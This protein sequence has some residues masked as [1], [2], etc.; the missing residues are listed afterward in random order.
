MKKAFL[1]IGCLLLLCL[2][3]QT[4]M[5]QD[6]SPPTVTFVAPG[7]GN[8]TRNQT[9]LLIISYSDPSGINTGSVSLTVDLGVYEADVTEWEST[10]ITE[11]NII[12]S[13]PESNRLDDGNYTVTVSVSDM[14]GNTASQTWTFYVNT[15]TSPSE[16]TA[17]NLFQY[18]VYA[19]I[20]AGIGGLALAVYILYLKKTKDFTFRKYFVQH[21][22][23]REYLVIYLPAVAALLFV[24]VG[25]AFVGS[26][27]SP[28]S[29]AY[30][31]VIIAG[32]LIGIGVYAVDAQLERRRVDKYERAFSQFLFEL[33]DVC[34]GGIDPTKG[35]IELSK[36]DTS[37]IQDHLQRAA[38]SIRIGRPLDEV[39]QRMVRPMKSDLIRRYTS[40]IEEAWKTG[41]DIAPVIYRAAKDMDDFIKI[42]LERRRQ[43]SIQTV[44]LYIGFAILLVVLYQLL[45]MFPQIEGLDI[46][47]L[48]GG[49]N[50]EGEA[51]RTAPVSIGVIR[52]R[53]FHLM[54]IYSLG[55]GALIGLFTDG[56]VKYGLIHAI[57]MTVATV[58]FFTL[59]IL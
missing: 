26:D 37:I 35:I 33:A 56:K 9:P 40:L 46:T 50:L 52:R 28:V 55:T 23:Q 39:L 16:E 44:V 41:G 1:V 20:G 8:E 47:L 19:L 13:Y 59:L 5:A 53:F 31:Y 7:P 18:A 24:I 32:V 4:G 51:S 2:A 42:G 54:V 30:E 34:R 57:I 49:P 27:P 45:H 43:L 36:T 21:P 25:F 10:R 58:M 17:L 12:F 22:V 38:D 29:Y 15:T 6:D 11:S 14:E 48:T 3:A